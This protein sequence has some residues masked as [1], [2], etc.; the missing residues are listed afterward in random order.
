MAWKILR[1]VSGII[2]EIEAIITSA[3][4]GDSGKVIAAD[5]SGKLD[6]SFLPTGVGAETKAIASSENL[7]AGDFV[8]IWD[9]S[10]T[11]KARKADASGGVAKRAHGFV[12]S[13]VTSPANATV[14]MEGINTQCSGLTGGTNYFLSGASAGLPTATAPSTTAYIVQPI[15]VALSATEIS[16]APQQPIVLA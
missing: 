2:T 5:A 11:P 13:A 15:G 9:D 1:L 6:S 8:N 16:F 12:L 10:G 4:A 3:G 14:Y 7:A